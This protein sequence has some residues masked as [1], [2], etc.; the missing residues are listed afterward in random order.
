MSTTVSLASRLGGFVL[1]AVFILLGGMFIALG[2]TFLPII[3]I[4]MAI[5]LLGLSLYFLCPLGQV[6]IRTEPA[7]KAVLAKETPA[8]Q[9][10]PAVAGQTA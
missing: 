2:V 3:G 1:G 9:G 5:P 4:I 10:I 6:T 7:K 8:Q